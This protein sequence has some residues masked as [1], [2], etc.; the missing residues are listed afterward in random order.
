MS[1]SSHLDTL[2]ER[3]AA[4]ESKIKEEL[5]S[6]GSDTLQVNAL[7]RQKLHLKEEIEKISASVH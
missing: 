5:R 3:H 7:K 2:R 4:L 6:P 1:V